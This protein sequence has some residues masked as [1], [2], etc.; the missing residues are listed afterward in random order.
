MTEFFFIMEVQLF[1]IS[2]IKSYK[3]C[4]TIS[5]RLVIRLDRICDFTIV[6]CKLNIPF[7]ELMKRFLGLLQYNSFDVSIT[8]LLF[9]EI[10][11]TFVFMYKHNYFTIFSNIIS[12]SIVRY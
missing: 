11:F 2:D 6:F 10:K 7:Y 9:Q 12:I 8:I 3:Y 4:S 1:P 5:K